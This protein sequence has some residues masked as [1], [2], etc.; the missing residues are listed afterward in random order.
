M[1]VGEVDLVGDAALGDLGGD[2]D[3]LTGDLEDEDEY[4]RGEV[5]DLAV[6]GDLGASVS[7]TFAF[8]SSFVSNFDFE[9]SPLPPILGMLSFDLVLVRVKLDSRDLGKRGLEVESLLI[10]DLEGEETSEEG[11]NLGVVDMCSLDLV[12]EKEKLCLE[13]E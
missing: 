6:L 9:S 3:L 11:S 12:R 4:L 8:P 13:T 1:E 2:K 10:L 7:P 5:G